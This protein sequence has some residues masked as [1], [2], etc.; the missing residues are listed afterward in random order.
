MKYDRNSKIPSR[1]G[2]II[3]CISHAL[4]GTVMY[5]ACIIVFPNS[6][7]IDEDFLKNTS[8]IYYFIYLN[9]TINL[10]RGR[11]YF[12]WYLT[13]GACIMGCLGYEEDPKT[14][15]GSWDNIINVDLFKVE[16][17]T[18]IRDI[19]RYWNIGTQNWLSH[20]VYS[21]NRNSMI[22][23]YITSAI[24]HG[25]YMGYFVFFITVGIA[26]YVERSIIILI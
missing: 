1:S 13:S 5:L 6:K 2:A 12:A 22:A 25:F 3:K 7:L 17:S 16:L 24:W 23:V 26:Q 14:G 4:I 8:Y 15:K 9:I 18:S 10:I 21:R 11:Y 20:Y 19:T